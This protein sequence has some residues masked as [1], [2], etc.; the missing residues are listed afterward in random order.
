MAIFLGKPLLGQRDRPEAL[1]DKGHKVPVTSSLEK[2]NKQLRANLD[3]RNQRAIDGTP[4][5]YV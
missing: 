2:W 3:L 5:G 4:L 1:C